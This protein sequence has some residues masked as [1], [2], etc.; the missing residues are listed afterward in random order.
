[1][2]S[3]ASVGLGVVNI[4]VPGLDSLGM[5]ACGCT[6]A[7]V[8]GRR[9]SARASSTRDPC[10]LPFQ[11]RDSPPGLGDVNYV[12]TFTNQYNYIPKTL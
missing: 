3:C 10:Q 4:D 8:A 7:L 5:R 1:M 12:N 2:L 9:L 6:V 11:H